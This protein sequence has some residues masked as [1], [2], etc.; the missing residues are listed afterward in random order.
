M[1][2]TLPYKIEE[3]KGTK[4]KLNNGRIVNTDLIKKIKVGDWILVNA[5]L[6]LKKIT[7]KEAE[8]INNYLK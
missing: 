2:L 3:M 5:N 6:A 7:A 4:A 1:C 8:E